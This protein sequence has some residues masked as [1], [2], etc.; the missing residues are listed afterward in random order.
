MTFVGGGLLVLDGGKRASLDGLRLPSATALMAVS[1]PASM[2]RVLE[3]REPLD[4]ARWLSVMV[5]HSGA[6][7][8]TPEALERE[9]RAM[10]LRRLGHHFV[11]GNGNGMGDGE[12][13]VGARWLDQQPGAHAAGES[14]RAAWSNQHAISICLVGDGNRRGFTDAQIQ[15]LMELASLLASELGI[16]QDQIVLHSDESDVADPGVRF[17]AAAFREMVGGME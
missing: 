8:G 11:I 1:G 16:P 4:R 10:G 15:R 17:P 2:E 12:V 13:H 5:H 6:A 14:Q 9:H 3:T 7:F